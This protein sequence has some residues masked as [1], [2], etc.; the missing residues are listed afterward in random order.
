MTEKKTCSWPGK[1]PL[2]NEYH[3]K[4]W[5]VPVHDD[6]KHFEFLVLDAF[7]AGLS[8]AIVLKKR[9]G[10]RNHRILHTIPDNTLRDRQ[11]FDNLYPVSMDLVLYCMKTK[12]VQKSAISF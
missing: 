7:Q 5:G 12:T 6:L 8:W 1:D 10:F 11:Q 2:M 3:D 9:E 4:E